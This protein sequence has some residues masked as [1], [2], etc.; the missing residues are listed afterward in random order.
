MLGSRT[1]LCPRAFNTWQ[2]YSMQQAPHIYRVTQSTRR[3]QQGT[4]HVA[5]AATNWWSPR[6][7]WSLGPTLPKCVT[8]QSA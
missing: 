3:T 7:G 1:F 8:S 6:N 5:A 2:G 4:V